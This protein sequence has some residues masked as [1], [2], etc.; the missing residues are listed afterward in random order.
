MANLKLGHRYYAI[1]FLVMVS[2]WP[3]SASALSELSLRII[4]TVSLINSKLE[5]GSL[6]AQEVISYR[7]AI[8]GLRNQLKREEKQYDNERLSSTRYP[9]MY[10]LLD[11]SERL[12]NETD[13]SVRQQMLS[14]QIKLVVKRSND[15]DLTGEDLLRSYHVF[16]KSIPSKETYKLLSDNAQF[17]LPLKSFEAWW[18]RSVKTVAVKRVDK[19]GKGQYKIWLLY[20]LANGSQ[21]CSADWLQLIEGPDGWLID[22]FY[23]SQA[24]LSECLG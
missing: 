10:F 5:S 12:L 6:D 14:Q 16:A 15:S 18:G 8:V 13:Y 22:D 11:I 1:A 20:D 4:D 21:Q 24:M 9:E 23:W 2:F 19:L 7:Q 17:K 3:M